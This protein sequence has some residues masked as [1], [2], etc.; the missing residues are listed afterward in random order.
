MDIPTIAAILGSIKSATKSATDIAKL[1]K[2][3]DLS[4]KKA[5]VKLKLAD[6]ISTLA[7]AKIEIAEVQD[8]LREKDTKIRELEEFL[9]VK[10]KLAY[11]APYYWMVKGDKKDGPFCQQCYD[12]T[13]KLIRLQHRGVAGSWACRTCNKIF[14]DKDYRDPGPINLRPGSKWS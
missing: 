5:E 10:A 4:L 3:T 14:E 12:A 2:E 6:L 8:L 7:D 1:L 9:A 11:E 13:G